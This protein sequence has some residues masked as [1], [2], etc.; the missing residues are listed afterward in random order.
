[1]IFLL[2]HDTARTRTTFFL[3]LKC[4]R[5]L[6][7]PS[8]FRL[9]GMLPVWNTVPVA[10]ILNPFCDMSATV[11]CS[12]RVAVSI[13]ESRIKHPFKIKQIYSRV[14]PESVFRI[15]L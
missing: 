12:V 11:F 10:G 8:G 6:N 1:M 5:R 2:Q 4:Y 7:V 9:K 14:V 3:F 13:Q 15:G